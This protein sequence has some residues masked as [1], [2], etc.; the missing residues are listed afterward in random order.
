M[1]SPMRA[2]AAWMLARVTDSKR[3]LLVVS[4][5][6]GWARSRRI[7][8]EMK[9]HQPRCGWWPVCCLTS[10]SD[11]QTRLPARA[12]GLIIRMARIVRGLVLGRTRCMWLKR[13]EQRREWASRRVAG[14]RGATLRCTA[15]TLAPTRE[16]L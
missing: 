16:P 8:A 10:E 13:V 7:R 15:Q 5:F 9:N 6:W 14:T 4:D 12:M 2:R 1:A 3:F 11:C